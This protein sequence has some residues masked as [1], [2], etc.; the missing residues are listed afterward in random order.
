MTNLEDTFNECVF[1]EGDFEHR[2]VFDYA[3]ERYTIAH[4]GYPYNVAVKINNVF[5]LGQL[6]TSNG[7]EYFAFGDCEA[8]YLVRQMPLQS[9]KRS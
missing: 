5:H 7:K 6:G 1:T 3:G 8:G 9:I 4:D 2:K